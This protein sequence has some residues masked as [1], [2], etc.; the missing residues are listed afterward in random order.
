MLN[1]I[2]FEEVQNLRENKWVYVLYAVL[3]LLPYS[4]FSLLKSGELDL[5]SAA[6]LLFLF[7]VLVAVSRASLRVKVY[8]EGIV[9]RFLGFKGEVLVSAVLK[10][11]VIKLR[12]IVQFGGY[13]VR[14]LGNQ[15]LFA[16]KGDYA[17]A[18]HLNSGKTLYLGTQKPEEM[19][20]AIQ[21]WN[22]A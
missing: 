8:T 7:I 9:Y 4:F 2:L 18:L 6:F 1:T 3:L 15:V 11:E 19:E 14:W 22:C 20:R 17:L 16:T 5:F 10:A 12:P 21:A 13:G